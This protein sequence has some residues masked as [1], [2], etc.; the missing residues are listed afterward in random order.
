M[1]ESGQNLDEMINAPNFE[2]ERLGAKYWFEQYSKQREQN[3]QLQQ[4]FEQL[5]E[6]VARL[7][8]ELDKL[9]QRT[10]QNTSQPPSQDGYKKA[11]IAKSGKRKRGPKYGHE[12]RT[13]NGFG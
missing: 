8:E 3:Q 13:R 5:Q 6:Q 11:N 1:E 9:K 4:Q 12:G 2:P 7:Q 10:S